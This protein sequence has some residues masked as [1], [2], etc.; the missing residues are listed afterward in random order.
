MVYFKDHAEIIA[1]IAHYYKKGRAEGESTGSSY[2]L[3]LLG[4]QLKDKTSDKYRWLMKILVNLNGNRRELLPYL[5][6]HLS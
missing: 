6:R 1:N 3:R 4:K 2:R 5:A